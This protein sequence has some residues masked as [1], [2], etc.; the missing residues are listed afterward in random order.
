MTL[1]QLLLTTIIVFVILRTVIALKSKHLSESFFVVW[2][3]FWF[4]VLILIFRQDM[5]S[6]V[7]YSLGISRGVDLV[8]Y[9]SLIVI[10]Y[11]LYRFL[12]KLGELDSKITK[13][14]RQLALRDKKRNK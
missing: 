13:L 6:Q 8:I 1:S 10:F 2:L 4:G 12:A 3:L 9:I 7:A 5:V 14:V 11:M